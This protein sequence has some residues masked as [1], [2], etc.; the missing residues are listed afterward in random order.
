MQND[1]MFIVFL[2]IR[3][4]EIGLSSFPFNII[5]IFLFLFLV[6]SNIYPIQYMKSM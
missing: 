6:E 3:A 1:K 2:L 5:T 4:L